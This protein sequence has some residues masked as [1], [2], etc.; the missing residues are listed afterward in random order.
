MEINLE[1]TDVREGAYPPKGSKPLTLEEAGTDR[2]L[3][4]RILKW[5]TKGDYG[6][7]SPGFFGILLGGNSVYP[8]EWLILRI[9]GS[10]D[11]L[12]L[13][14]EKLQSQVNYKG[15]PNMPL[16]ALMTNILGPLNFLLVLLIAP[17]HLYR[18][19]IR[20]VWDRVWRKLYF[21]KISEVHFTPEQGL[22]KTK[23]LF[24]THVLEMPRTGTDLPRGNRGMIKGNR[25]EAWIISETG[26]VFC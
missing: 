26:R 22:I 1:I 25:L 3:N 5:G 4:R 24:K 2:I 7:G 16:F 14:G 19:L 12:L 18:L 20:P 11:W 13:D 9:P 8:K 21:S 15:V 23:N 17:Y 6:T 10:V